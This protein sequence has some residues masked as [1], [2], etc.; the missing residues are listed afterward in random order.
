MCLSICLTDT[1]HDQSQ[2]LRFAKLIG[3]AVLKVSFG[4]EEVARENR[5]CADLH[6]LV[7]PFATTHL[8]FLVFTTCCVPEFPSLLVIVVFPIG[9]NLRTNCSQHPN[10]WS[11][12]AVQRTTSHVRWNHWQKVDVEVLLLCMFFTWLVSLSLVFDLKL[13]ILYKPGQVGLDDRMERTGP[14]PSIQHSHLP[15]LN[16][17]ATAPWLRNSTVFWIYTSNLSK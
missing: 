15:D 1:C 2:D 8:T 13:W 16:L 17:R 4:Q 12:M 10:A 9:Q 6:K 11:S 7:E 14:I 5:Y 3:V